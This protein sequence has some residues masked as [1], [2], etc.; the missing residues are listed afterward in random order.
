MSGLTSNTWLGVLTY[1][2]QL[3]FDF[4]GYSD[5]AHRPGP[6]LLHPV[7]AQ[8]Q[9]TLQIHQHH[10]LLAAL[11]Y[12]VVG[13]TSPATSTRRFLMSIT[14]RRQ[15]PGQ[16]GRHSPASY[17]GKAIANLVAVPTLF[18]LFLA[19]VWHGAGLQFFAYGMAHGIGI[20][21]NH[22][23]RTF[24]PPQRACHAASS[25]DPSPILLTFLFVMLASSCSSAPTACTM[26][27]ASTP[28]CSAATDT[29]SHVS[30][31][32]LHQVHRPAA[33]RRLVHAQHPGDP[34]PA[35][36]PRRT[37]LV[38][39]QTTRLRLAAHLHLVGRRRRHHAH[40]RRPTPPSQ[41][42]SST[43]SS[44]FPLARRLPLDPPIRPRFQH[45]QR[46]CPAVQNLIMERS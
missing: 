15:R 44:K 35:R 41:Q 6:H 37:Q 2:L 22:A 33:R 24:V 13:S 16:T 27:S 28:A 40:R 7:S 5:M 11:A 34:R 17:R 45:I 25:T 31:R 42:P 10:R 23:W 19:G 32:A 9:L 38:A 8:L 36:R 30:L 18:T 21:F 12:D 14:R 20:S 26:P 43:S 29:A 1:A 46:Q 39:H 3:Y 4:S